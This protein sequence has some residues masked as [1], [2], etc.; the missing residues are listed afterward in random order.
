MEPV[1]VGIIGLGN[2]GSSIVRMMHQVPGAELTAVCDTN[3]KAFERLDPAV[4]E[5]VAKYTTDE[6]FFEKSGVELAMIEVPH[7]Q[8]ADLAIAAMEH[9]MHFNVEK[10]LCVDKADGER[11]LAECAKHPELVKG[12]MLNQRTRDAHIK[13]KQLIDSGELG[14]IRRVNWII[15]DW[16]RTQQY[17]DSGDWRASWRGEGG[18]VLTN[19]CP[20]QLDLMTWLFGMPSLVDAHIFL[21]KYHDIEVED[22]VNAYLEYPNG[23][24][25]NF[26]TTTG[27]APGTNRLEIAAEHGRVVFENNRLL[28]KR[29]AI[30]TQEHIR[31]ATSGFTPPE[32]WD[33]EIH[34]APDD[35]GQ[36]QHMRVLANVVEAIR[37]GAP[38][39]APVE[40]GIRGLEL[41]NAMMLSGFLKKPVSLPLDSRIYAEKLKELI[42]TSRYPK[43]KAP[44]AE[45]NAVDFTK[46]F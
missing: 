20:H 30:T 41:A 16:Y 14:E 12:I 1:K 19:Q 26:I 37:N 3:P 17:Y 33:C 11:L 18:G 29:H 4:R 24:T 8:H 43:K 44:A 32:T 28:Y 5:K 23:A 40:E 25:A 31:T 22:E 46:S 39:K 9:G 34:F 45:A 6:E 13:I 42:A 2:M 27:E 21:G 15:T 36:S 38:L 10:P 35:A 7:F